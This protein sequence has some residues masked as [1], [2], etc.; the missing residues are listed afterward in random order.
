MQCY[1]SARRARPSRPFNLC[2]VSKLAKVAKIIDISQDVLKNILSFSVLIPHAV[3]NLMQTNSVYQFGPF[4][5]LPSE[6]LLLRGE[7]VVELPPKVFDTLVMLVRESGH[8]VEKDEIM[9]AIWPDS[10][11]E[12]SNLTRNISVLRKALNPDSSH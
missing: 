12:E 4:Q 7:N 11:V 5:L 2:P 8:V 3:L 10:F 6:R 9:R 1:N